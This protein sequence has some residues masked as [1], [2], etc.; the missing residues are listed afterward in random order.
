M[1]TGPWAV[2]LYTMCFTSSIIGLFSLLSPLISRTLLRRRSLGLSD[3]INPFHANY[4]D[5]LVCVVRFCCCLCRWGSAILFL[6]LHMA[7]RDSARIKRV[8]AQIFIHDA[9]RGVMHASARLHIS[10]RVGRKTGS[11]VL[12]YP[13]ERNLVSIRGELVVF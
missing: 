13:S 10:D 6:F 8:D 3:E 7:N 11:S 5:A 1:Y 9:A 4:S 2:L 12:G